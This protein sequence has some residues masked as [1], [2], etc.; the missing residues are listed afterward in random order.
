MWEASNAGTPEL[1]AS[2]FSATV[3]GWGPRF[4]IAT[5]GRLGLSAERV[6]MDGRGGALV[7]WSEGDDLI[8]TR[9]YVPA[10]GWLPPLA[11]I[12]AAEEGLYDVAMRPN[13]AFVL[14]SDAAFNLVIAQLESYIWG[15]PIRLVSNFGGGVGLPR[16]AV[17]RDAPLGSTVVVWAQ[18]DGIYFNRITLNGPEFPTGQKIPGS[19]NG[20]EP[21]V[22]MGANEETT[23]IWKVRL[24][25]T[26][27]NRAIG[28]AWGA[29]ESI[30]GGS[31]N[32]R[33]VGDSLGNAAHG[34]ER[35][36]QGV[37]DAIH[38]RQRLAT[39]AGNRRRPGS[40][41]CRRRGDG[42]QRPCS[43][44]VGAGDHRDA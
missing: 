26:L 37:R 9:I 16:L 19:D 2:Q 32:A 20:T 14:Y 12:S 28:R 39:A 7:A 36:R 10:Q 21:Q 35:R 33:L 42:R 11:P 3:G 13:Q 27:A 38:P 41:G 34:L 17:H 44:G 15:A 30:A 25:G 4:L 1:Y 29:A 23:V 40:A 43:G 18:P 5:L 8:R 31:P 22:V 6:A 24:G